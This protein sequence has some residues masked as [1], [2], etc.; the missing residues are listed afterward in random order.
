MKTI[1]L[2]I[3]FCLALC[4]INAQTT[5]TQNRYVV[6]FADKNNSSFTI[7]DSAQFLSARAL[8]RRVNQNIHISNSDL[9]VS[10]TYV[11]AILN[12]GA[13]VL[14]TSKWLNFVCVQIHD[15]TEL[16]AISQLPFVVSTKLVNRVEQPINQLPYDKF[17]MEQQVSIST[18]RLAGNP[19][20]TSTNT[21]N[22]NYGLS[23]NQINQIGGDALHSMNYMG[24]GIQIAVFD[25]GFPNVDTLSVFDSLRLNNRLLGYRNF[26]ND[27]IGVFSSTI[28]SHGTNTLS[29][30]AAWREGQL[31]GTAPRAS[32]YL[33][34]TEYAP[35][36]TPYEEV[37]WVAAAELADSLG[38]DIISSSL[39]YTSFNNATQSYTNASLDGNTAICTRGAD[40]AANKGILVVNSAGNEGANSWQK[41][42]A[43]SDGDSVLSIGAVNASGI[44]AS[45]SGKGPSADGRVKP[46]LCAQG[47]ATIIAKHTGGF[48]SANGTSF[49]CPVL[50]GMAACLW[51]AIPNATNMQLAQAIKASASQYNNPDNLMGYGIPNFSN[52]LFIITET[53]F[54]SVLKTEVKNIFPVPFSDKINII[55]HSLDTEN[56]DVNIADIAG[57]NVYNKTFRATTNAQNIFVCDDVEKLSAGVYL[58]SLRSSKEV[59]THKIVRYK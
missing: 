51:Q 24:Q 34:V 17:E 47:E 58:M 53:S 40:Y 13:K 6:Y 57:K 20:F 9:P 48:Q 11:N 49:S 25:A 56:I 30:M 15:S 1:A 41:I 4:E 52:A 18:A 12:T 2:I 10:Q 16:T 14:H 59:F 7:N 44:R 54:S 28:N 5:L 31:V 33:F 37:C 39:G 55:Y 43:P 27:S 8:Q 36:E 29:C 46:D 45:F 38:V 3:I 42:S 23:F 19:S 50:A 22:I 35:T 26:V 32:Y 21:N